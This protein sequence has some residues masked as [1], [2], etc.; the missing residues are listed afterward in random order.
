[1]T[2]MVVK[3]LA[4]AWARGQLAGMGSRRFALP[5]GESRGGEYSVAQRFRFGLGQFAGQRE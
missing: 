2:A 1:M 3:A 4:M 5:A